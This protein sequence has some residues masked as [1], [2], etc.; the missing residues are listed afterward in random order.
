MKANAAFRYSE[1]TREA[2]SGGGGG[3]D[4]EDDES[5]EQGRKSGNGKK[6]KRVR[7]KLK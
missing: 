3:E 1:N 7:G 5:M 4:E 2:G 6:V